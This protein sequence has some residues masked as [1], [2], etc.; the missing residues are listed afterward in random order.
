MYM[1][2]RLLQ[3]LSYTFSQALHRLRICLSMQHKHEIQVP[4]LGGEDS[5]EGEM[6]THSSILVWIIPRTKEPGRLSSMGLQRAGHDWANKQLE[7]V[8]GDLDES[9]NLMSQEEF[10]FGFKSFFSSIFY[11][12][13]SQNINQEIQHWDDDGVEHWD[14]FTSV[15]GIQ[16]AGSWVNEEQSPLVDGHRCQVGSTGREGILPSGGRTDL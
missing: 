14:D 2:A 1:L 7:F 3:V 16:I 6:A 5:L 9:W 8:I 4:S 11:V 12:S 15:G 10:I 13:V